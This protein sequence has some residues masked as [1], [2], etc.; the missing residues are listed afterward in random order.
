MRATFAE[1]RVFSSLYYAMNYVSV[2]RRRCIRV[3]V[4]IRT[5]SLRDASKYVR[6]TFFGKKSLRASRIIKVISYYFGIVYYIQTY[7]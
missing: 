4:D 5:E 1:G 6:L 3:Y 7:P 2:L